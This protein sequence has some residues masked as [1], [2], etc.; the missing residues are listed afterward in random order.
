MNN[1]ETAI[2][3]NIELAPYL[4]AATALIGKSRKI[5]GNQFRHVWATVGILID[6]K[7][8][9]PVILKAG[10]LH[11]LKEDSPDNYYPDQISRIDKDGPR[12]VQVVEELSRPIGEPKP[13]Y[14][15][16]VMTDSSKEAKII[17]L[18]D[19]ISNL[20]DIQLG[21]FDIQGVNKT[22]DETIKYILPY[23]QDINENMY[24]EMADLISS[25]TKYVQRTVE[26][27]T[28]K[29]I[30][31][32]VSKIN[33]V[34]DE[35][36]KLTELQIKHAINNIVSVEKM[37]PQ[38]DTELENT[39]LNDI[40]GLGKLIQNALLKVKDDISSDITSDIFTDYNLWN[41][42]SK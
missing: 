20:T 12:V 11:D 37:L 40:N 10:V 29:V 23:A 6:H 31:N 19:R 32:I 30:D 26:L 15:I 21:I 7:I 14:L 1:N 9:N 27:I 3:K 24:L 18:A 22:L 13:E 5:G 36:L 28:C 39:I 33:N 38:R 35:Y 25:R 4:Q 8:I 16:R 34:N 42:E 2:L 17:K 41:V